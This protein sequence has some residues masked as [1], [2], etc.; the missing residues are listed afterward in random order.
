M[1]EMAAQ[2]LEY[3]HLPVVIKPN[4]GLPRFENGVAI[5]DV[6]PEEFAAEMEKVASLGVSGIGG[7]CG[8]TPEFIKLLAEI[9]RKGKSPRP[10]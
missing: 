6:E 8:T 3:T 4:A 7:C 1:R 10:S 9:A 5:Y 2:L